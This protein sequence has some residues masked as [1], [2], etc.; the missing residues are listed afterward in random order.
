MLAVGPSGFSAYYC[1]RSRYGRL[2]DLQVSHQY[3]F[4][5]AN[6]AYAQAHLFSSASTVSST[7]TKVSVKVIP[8]P[9]QPDYLRRDR[10]LFL[11]SVARLMAQSRVTVRDLIRSHWCNW[12]SPLAVAILH[13][14]R[15]SS[16][17]RRWRCAIRGI[18]ALGLRIEDGHHK[19]ACAAMDS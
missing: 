15:G 6:L 7:V 18:G 8:H 17:A 10:R 2:Y 11:C 1:L 16:G 5:A 3:E 19:P 13:S 4:S 14:H 9:M 12:G